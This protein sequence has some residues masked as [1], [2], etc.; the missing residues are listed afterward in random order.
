MHELSLCMDVID[1][2]TALAAEHNARAVSS[3]TVRI[4]VLS[5]VEPLLLE[6]AFSI[7]QAGT[8]AENSRFITEPVSARV[9]CSHCGSESEVPPHS[10]RC[11]SCGSLSTRLI[12][13]DELTLASVELAVED[14]PRIPGDE[15]HS[16]NRRTRLAEHV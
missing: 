8:I 5:G 10:L 11:N 15:C 9:H 14:E 1:Q 12:S 7:A 13:G 3:I 16:S 6:S 4:G 2:V